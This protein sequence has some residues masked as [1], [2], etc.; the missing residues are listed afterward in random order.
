[1]KDEA[2]KNPHSHDEVS[3][4]SAF[5]QQ[6]DSST[7]RLRTVMIAQVVSFDAET[8]TVDVQPCI[9]RKFMGD[10]DAGALPIIG[11]VPVMYFGGGG[12]WITITPRKDDYCVLLI[13]DRSLEQWKLVGGIVNPQMKRHHDMTD[14]C[15]YFGI[16]PFEDALEDVMEDTLH[17]RSRDG[18]AG[19]SIEDDK[20]SV[21]LDDKKVIDMTVDQIDNYID[22]TIAL[23]ITKDTVTTFVDGVRAIKAT[24]SVVTTYV[25]GIPAIVATPAA[26]SV[27]VGGSDKLTVAAG[28]AAFTVPVTAPDFLTTAGVSLQTHT[29]IGNLSAPT[30]PPS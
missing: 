28:V 9:K 15:A 8:N 30:S 16:N 5:S 6:F 27:K 10:E 13:S 21:H 19:V 18:K 1:M 26:I 20:V 23:K 14:A 3:G 29:H 11:D 7:L 2:I 22:D 17:L 12:F 24:A 4:S 25:D